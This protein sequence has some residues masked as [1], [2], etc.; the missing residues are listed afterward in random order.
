MSGRPGNS[1]NFKAVRS[2]RGFPRQ[3]QLEGIGKHLWSSW[4]QTQVLP[5]L[6]VASPIFI[7]KGNVRF[8]LQ[9]NEHDAVL[10]PDF[11][12]VRGTY[13]LCCG[14]PPATAPGGLPSPAPSL[15]TSSKTCC[16][17]VSIGPTQI[18]TSFGF[19]ECPCIEKWTWQWP[20]KHRHTPASHKTS[21]ERMWKTW[22]PPILR[23]GCKTLWPLGKT[24][25][26]I[27]QKVK[28]RI[29]TWPS[30]STPM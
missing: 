12:R 24:V 5:M 2:I 3:Q 29:I 28:H 19:P 8:Q 27:P 21:A 22:S 11:C 13:R 9:V 23:W 1:C 14:C 20:W 18:N 26:A 10:F 17:T 6:T 16:Y 7:T 30:N 25:L 4:W 15:W